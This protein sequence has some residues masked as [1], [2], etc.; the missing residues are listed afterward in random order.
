MMETWGVLEDRSE[1]ELH[2]SRLLNVEERPFKR[3][4]KRLQ[5]LV[6]S[7]AN[8]STSEERLNQQR[9]LE[10]LKDD[11][12]TDFA[13]FDSSLSRLQFLFDANARQR[14]LYETDKQRILD[15]CQAARDENATLREKLDEARTTLSKRKRF[16]DLADKITANRLLRPRTDQLTSLKKLEEECAELERERETYAETWRERRDQFN[17]IMEEGM[18]LR[19]QIRDEADEVD[20][21]QGMVEE[22]DEAVE[23]SAG[24]PRPG[25]ASR[26]ATPRPDATKGDSE[27]AMASDNGEGAAAKDKERLGS[28]LRGQ[29]S[30]SRSRSCA[31]SRSIREERP[32]ETGQRSADDADNNDDGDD[33]EIEEG[34]DVEMDDGVSKGHS[35][36]DAPRMMVDGSSQEDMEMDR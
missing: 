3:V 35:V 22:E 29:L 27:V 5:T 17:R 18:L 30:R 28:T 34:E 14:D 32:G 15:E 11:L 10:F 1:Q 24:T 33:G 31:S 36:A 4:T 7:L 8:T 26:S 13:I 25:P 20:R 9:M 16:D 21:R 2:K 23:A 19:A 12:T 6:T